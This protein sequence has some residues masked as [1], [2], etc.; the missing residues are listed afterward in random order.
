M[1]NILE[2]FLKKHVKMQ[3]LVQ[4][5]VKLPFNMREMQKLLKLHLD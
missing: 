4:S 5:K 3:N 2:L 1:K